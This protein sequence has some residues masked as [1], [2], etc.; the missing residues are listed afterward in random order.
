MVL[1]VENAIKRLPPTLPSLLFSPFSPIALLFRH[2]FALFHL[3]TC[4][5]LFSHF[6]NFPIFVL[7]SLTFSHFPLFLFFFLVLFFH[8]VFFFFTLFLSF[9][10]LFDPLF[11]TFPPFFGQSDA[12]LCAF[13]A[14]L[15]RYEPPPT[16]RILRRAR[17]VVKENLFLIEP[18]SAHFRPHSRVHTST[19][20]QRVL[21]LQ[22]RET[23]FFTHLD[24]PTRGSPHG[25]KPTSHSR[26]TYF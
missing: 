13:L 21:I 15:V 23:H 14:S 1:W 18:V 7:Y 6:H 5:S 12:S 19:W 2:F 4:Y 24:L 25:R 10:P 3:H 17:H 8:C 20:P 22:M 11:N 9:S 26:K 16:H